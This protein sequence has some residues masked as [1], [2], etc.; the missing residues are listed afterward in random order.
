[1]AVSRKYRAQLRRVNGCECKYT[2][3]PPGGKYD[4]DIR[5]LKECHT[6][7]TYYRRLLKK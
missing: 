6:L 2:K 3:R 5:R 1:M 4:P 7:K